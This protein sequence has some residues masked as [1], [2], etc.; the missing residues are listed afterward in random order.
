MKALLNPKE[1]TS[2]LDKGELVNL[3]ALLTEEIEASLKLL[4]T[5]TTTTK[6]KIQ[7]IEVPTEQKK[8]K[9]N[10]QQNTCIQVC[11]QNKMHASG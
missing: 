9:K 3:K 5:F 6:Y 4:V 8:K 7:G 1:V 11:P 10:L 2:A